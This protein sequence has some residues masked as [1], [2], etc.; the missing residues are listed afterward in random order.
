DDA[1]FCR[2]V[3]VPRRGVGQTSIERIEEVAH[4][5]G[6]SMMSAVSGLEVGL[7]PRQTKAIEGF[8]DLIWRLSTLDSITEMLDRL[9]TESG[10]LAELEADRSVEGQARLENVQEL[11]SVAHDFERDSDDSSLGAFLTQMAL[12]SELDGAKEEEAVTLMTLHSAKGLEFPVVFLAGME[13]GIFP[14]KRTFDHPAELE[15]ERRICY[16][17]ITRARERLFLSYATR[18]MIFGQET[19]GFPSRFLAEIPEELLKKEGVSREAR[20]TIESSGWERTPV[21]DE[22][23][24]QKKSKSEHTGWQSKWRNQAKQETR[25]PEWTEDHDVAPR[26]KSLFEVGDKVVHPSFGHG[27]VAKVMGQGDRVCVAVAFPGLGQKILDLRYAP[28][29]AAE[30]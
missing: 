18:R 13:E 9:L 30:D 20:Q 7:G 12:L 24:W 11:R 1:A 29:K 3:H 28:L 17:G 25:E 6:V 15:E 26:K 10:Y 27:V 22:Y 8:K 4:A 14:H 21:A 16:V 23:G 2:V 5:H 19:P